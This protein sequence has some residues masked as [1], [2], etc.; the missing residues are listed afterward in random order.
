MTYDRILVPL[1]GSQLAEYILPHVEALALAF[2]GE[3][4]LLHV[5]EGKDID[6]QRLTP[7]QRKARA[8]IVKYLEKITQTLAQKQVQAVWWVSFG[9][10]AQE[11]ARRAAESYADL[12]MMSTHGRGGQEQERVGS[13]AMAVV[14]SG[15]T[16]VML[17]RPPEEVFKR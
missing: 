15:T 14:S 8:D 16:P 13:V 17:V 9:D 12:V 11:I 6:P 2:H 4:N 3:V 5:V 7:S 10:P 1:D